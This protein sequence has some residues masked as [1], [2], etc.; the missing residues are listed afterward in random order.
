MRRPAVD[1][2]FHSESGCALGRIYWSGQYVNSPGQPVHAMNEL[3]FCYVT[4]GLCDF[5][6]AAGV[7]R[8]TPGD[9]MVLPP[10]RRRGYRPPPGETWDERYITCCGPLIDLWRQLDLIAAEEEVWRLLPVDYWV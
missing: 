2:P 1:F 10:G 7:R 9:L 4:R 3:V 8:L 5:E 6:S